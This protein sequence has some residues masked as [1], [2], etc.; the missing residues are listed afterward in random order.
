MNK[1][2]KYGFSAVLAAALMVSAAMPVGA[3][4]E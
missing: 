3:E 1:G 2:K 4:K